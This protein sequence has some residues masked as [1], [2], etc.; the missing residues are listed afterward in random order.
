MTKQ[1]VRH[2]CKTERRMKIFAHRGRYNVTD[3]QNRSEVLSAS[4]APVL[5]GIGTNTITNATIESMHIKNKN[6]LRST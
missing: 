1:I 4:V 3:A 2:G 6:V 5:Y